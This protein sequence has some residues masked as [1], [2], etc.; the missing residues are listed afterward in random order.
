MGNIFLMKG[1]WEINIKNVPVF[2]RNKTNL[3]ISHLP[4]IYEASAADRK[5]NC[6]IAWKA[7]LA[8]SDS[9]LKAVTK[10]RVMHIHHPW[11]DLYSLALGSCLRGGS[12]GLSGTLDTFLQLP[13]GWRCWPLT[14]NEHSSVLGLC[15]PMVQA[16]LHYNMDFPALAIPF[17]AR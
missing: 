16:W 14:K 7:A 12:C 2:S 5:G 3:F 6:S 13:K 10:G 9:L 4:C 11:Q 15:P 8:G 17:L 1:R